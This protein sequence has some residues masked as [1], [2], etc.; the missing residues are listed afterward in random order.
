MTHHHHED[1]SQWPYVQRAGHPHIAQH[2]PW[3][4]PTIQQTD[5]YRIYGPP[6][7]PKRVNHVLHLV[8]TLFTVGFWVPVWFMVMIVVHNQNTQADAEYWA[9]IQRYWRWELAQQSVDVS[10]QRLESGP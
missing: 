3:G 2:V 10:Q 8:L 9:R 7:I 5:A 4:Y 6:P 1:W